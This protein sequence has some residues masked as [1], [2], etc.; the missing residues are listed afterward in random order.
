[1]GYTDRYRTTAD[2]PGTIPV[3]PLAGAIL[4]PRGQLPLNIFETRYLKMIDDAVRGERIVGMVQPDGDEAIIASQIEGRRPPL[5]AT[6]CAGRITSFAETD[7]GRMIITLTG[8]CRFRLATELRTLTPYRQFEVEWEEFAHDL[9]PGHGQD[10]VARERLLE[11]LKE[12]LDTHG[13]QADWRAIKLSSNETLVNSLC[14]ISPYGPREKQALLEARTLEDRNQ[15][16]IALTEKALREL[17]PGDTTV[18]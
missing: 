5:C 16:L 15:M 9:I 12:Y 3:F 10:E 1:M 13:L 4:L 17:A 7:D 2:L 11:V 14:T 8:I 18:Q 6:G